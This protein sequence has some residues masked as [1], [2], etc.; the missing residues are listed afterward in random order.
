MWLFPQ[1]AVERYGPGLSLTVE[2]G[3]RDARGGHLLVRHVDLCLRGGALE[4]DR[5]RPELNEIAGL[6][7]NG[8]LTDKARVRWAGSSCSG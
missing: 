4:R 5:E 3:R 8:P 1:V 2:S 6:S 7:T